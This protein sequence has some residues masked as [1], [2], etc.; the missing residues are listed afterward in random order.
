MLKFIVVM[1]IMSIIKHKANHT[2]IYIIAH[3]QNIASAGIAA[4]IAVLVVIVIV[5]TGVAIVYYR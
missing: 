4:S 1:T 3:D 5:F 2:F